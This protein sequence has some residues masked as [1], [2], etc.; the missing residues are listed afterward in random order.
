MS[1]CKFKDQRAF[2]WQGILENDMIYILKPQ[3]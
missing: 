3:L 1:M 2:T